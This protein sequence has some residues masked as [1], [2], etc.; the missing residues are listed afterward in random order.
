M[1][2][3]ARKPSSSLNLHDGGELPHVHQTRFGDWRS[4]STAYKSTSSEL[5]QSKKQTMAQ[6]VPT[7]RCIYDVI[8]PPPNARGLTV[9]ALS[10]KGRA[11]YEWE[12]ERKKL[13]AA[14]GR[15][16]GVGWLHASPADISLAWA[17]LSM[18]QRKPKYHSVSPVLQSLF[19]VLDCL[20]VCFQHCSC[21]IRSTGVQKQTHSRVLPLP[22]ILF[23]FL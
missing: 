13:Q 4:S 14:R 8:K 7:R 16:L 1:L 2:L 23:V 11:E 3:G 19:C 10:R 5:K 15:W 21:C 20:P 17:R 18:I 6:L 22:V 9:P 12:E